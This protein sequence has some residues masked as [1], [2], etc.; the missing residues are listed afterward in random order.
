MLLRMSAGMR[1][2]IAFFTILSQHHLRRLAK[3]FGKYA[4]GSKVS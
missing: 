4:R 3:S 2:S 1:A